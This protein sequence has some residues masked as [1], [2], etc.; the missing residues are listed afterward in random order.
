MNDTK[1][2]VKDIKKDYKYKMNNFA[3]WFTAIIISNFAYLISIRDEVVDEDLWVM[4]FYSASAALAL[5][6]IIKVSG[7]Y[8][9]RMRV[10]EKG[11]IPPEYKIESARDLLSAF[12][13]VIG[14]FSLIVTGW[15][16]EINIFIVL[17]ATTLISIF[18]YMC[19][20]KNPS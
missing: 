13:I 6:F 17:A 20:P 19:S 8:A 2:E 11:S 9:A 7:V 3:D 16:L 5:I 4:S 14:L 1:D 18:V 15:I 10:R 12:F